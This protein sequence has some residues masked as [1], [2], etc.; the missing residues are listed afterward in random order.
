MGNIKD[1][2]AM[3]PG[4]GKA[5]KDIDISDADEIEYHE[6]IVQ[7]NVFYGVL[8]KISVEANK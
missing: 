8:N 5:I 6:K 3:I 1:L 4:V 7:G 2:L